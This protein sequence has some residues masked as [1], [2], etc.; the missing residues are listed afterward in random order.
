MQVAEQADEMEAAI[1]AEPLPEQSPIISVA[2]GLYL[3]ASEC[4]LDVSCGWIPGVGCRSGSKSGPYF[5]DEQLPGWQYRKL[6]NAK[7]DSYS[8]CRQCVD[9]GCGWCARLSHRR[10]L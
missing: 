3:S 5:W 7:C 8:D 10:W 4:I 2:C 9:A 6:D 1:V